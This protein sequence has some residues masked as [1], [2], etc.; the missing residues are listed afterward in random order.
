MYFKYSFFFS[1]GIP[2]QRIRPVSPQCDRS[3]DR[4][5]RASNDGGTGCGVPA[6][7]DRRCHS[8]VYGHS[9]VR[10][11]GDRE[12]DCRWSPVF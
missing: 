2:I 10:R 8:T 3:E 12:E 11:Q 6:D 9:M 4:L 1:R 7:P 5:M